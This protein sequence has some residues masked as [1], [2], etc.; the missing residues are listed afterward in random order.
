MV[1]FNNL[2]GLFEPK[3]F[4]DSKQ[5]IAGLLATFWDMQSCRAPL[6][7]VQFSITF[8]FHAVLEKGLQ[9]SKTLFCHLAK[10]EQI[11]L[12]TNWL[13]H[14]QFIADCAI[15]VGQ[16][17][18]IFGRLFTCIYC[19]LPVQLAERV[20][21]QLRACW[22]N[23]MCYSVFLIQHKVRF[24]GPFGPPWHQEAISEHPRSSWA[25]LGKLRSFRQFF[26]RAI[27]LLGSLHEVLMFFLRN[28]SI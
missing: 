9:Y 13:L 10:R 22:C 28:F 8:P 7:K 27:L 15:E 26:S 3:W 16:Q 19:W 2:R 5:N 24:P 4:S 23:A 18:T 1:G 6:C 21:E 11:N 12:E 20:T 14:F 17:N 25:A